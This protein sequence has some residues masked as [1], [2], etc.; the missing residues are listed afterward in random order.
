MKAGLAANIFAVEAIRRAGLAL[1]ATIFQQSVVEEESTG[2]GALAAV[3]RGYKADGALITEPTGELIRR[4]QVGVIWIRVE[5]TAPPVHAGRRSSTGP[6]VIESCFPLVQA[7]NRL[8]ERWNAAKPPSFAA[9]DK[10]IK[11]VVSKIGGGEW[12]SSTP[13]SCFFEARIAIYPERSVEECQREIEATLFEAAETVPLL[14]EFPPLIRYHGF[15]SSGYVLP[16]ATPIELEL[17]AAHRCVSGS[18]ADVVVHTALTDARFFVLYQDTPCMVYG[19]RV[20]NIH[21][22]DEGVD[23]ESLRRVT[24]VAAL[25]IAAW[26]GVTTHKDPLSR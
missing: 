23:L 3:V 1:T 7:L 22:F 17:A 15:L 21:G 10:P 24:Q 2:N 14:K 12:T 13:S 9:V 4:G 26:C 25:F 20:S 6:N 16:P 8:E 5:L 11:I 18:A 19:P